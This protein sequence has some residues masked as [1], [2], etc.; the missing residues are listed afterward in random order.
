MPRLVAEY[1]DKAERRTRMQ[2][3][4]R[5]IE[6]TWELTIG[7]WGMRLARMLGVRRRGVR[8][9][10]SWSGLREGRPPYLNPTEHVWMP[11]HVSDIHLVDL[12]C[13]GSSGSSI[14]NSRLPVNSPKYMY[15][16]PFQDLVLGGATV[17]NLCSLI[18]KIVPYDRC[19]IAHL[20]SRTLEQT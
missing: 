14:G 13:P 2:G 11:G 6:V 1:R 5:G 15:R 7:R 9:P 17:I 12:F 20:H 8:L 10:F 19:L 16:P 18:S 3:H 4:R